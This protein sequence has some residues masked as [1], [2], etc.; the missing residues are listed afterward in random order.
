MVTLK[1]RVR[2]L[3]AYN[4][5]HEHYCVAL[6]RCECQLI[7]TRVMAKDAATGAVGPREQQRTA[8]PVLTL[9]AGEERPG[10]PVA[11]LAAPSIAAAIRRGD[12]RVQR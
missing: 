9:L 6:G 11:V 7:V 8:P 1:H 10:V 12:I 5:D 3:R 4:L 2:A